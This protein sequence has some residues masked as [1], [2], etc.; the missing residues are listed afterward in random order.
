MGGGSEASWGSGEE[1]EV[2]ARLVEEDLEGEKHLTANH[3]PHCL[4]SP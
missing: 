3:N 4:M 2:R 1:G